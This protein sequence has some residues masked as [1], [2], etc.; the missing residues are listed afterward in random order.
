MAPAFEPL[1]ASAATKTAKYSI[2]SAPEHLA[3]EVAQSKHRI[4]LI[5]FWRIPPGSRVLE[6]GCGQATCTTVLAEAV[7]PEGHVDAVDPG[8]PDY[9]APYTLAQAQSH[10]SAGPVGGRVAWHHAEP[11]EFLARNR[12]KTWDFVVMAHCIWYFASPET[13]AAM[14]S[15]LKGRV[16]TLVVAEYALTAAEKAAVPHVLASIARASLVAHNKASQENIRCL[17][18]PGSIKDAAQAGGW[19]LDSEC[20]V[21]PDEGLLD[22]YWETSTVKSKAFTEEVDTHVQDSTVK[23]MLISSRD[24]VIGALTALDGKKART[25]DVWIA[26]FN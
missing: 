7:G 13:L 20:V 2:I 23:T 5:N 25:L 17:L 18:R 1:P 19:S 14:L 8:P 15:A 12:D 6:I 9:G 11:I 24:A 4:Q 26:R 10:I 3:L 21:V 16:D 22:G